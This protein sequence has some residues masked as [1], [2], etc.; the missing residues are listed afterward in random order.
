MTTEEIRGNAYWVLRH[1][2]PNKMRASQISSKINLDY[3]KTATPREVHDALRNFAR[4]NKHFSI[5]PSFFP[6]RIKY[7]VYILDE[8]YCPEP[9]FKPAGVKKIHLSPLPIDITTITG[10]SEKKNN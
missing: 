9:S 7:S 8:P 10:E 2:Y 5:F 3:G 6:R 1:N 4:Q